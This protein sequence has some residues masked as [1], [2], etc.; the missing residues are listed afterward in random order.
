MFTHSVK[1]IRIGLHKRL[2]TLRK[3]YTLAAYLEKKFTHEVRK[4]GKKFTFLPK[5][6][7]HKV[8]NHG[9]SLHNLSKNGRKV[10]TE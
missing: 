1:R 8:R 2:K 3:V 7:T 4:H 5:K 9:N 10:Y 6:F